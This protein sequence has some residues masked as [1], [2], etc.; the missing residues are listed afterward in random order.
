MKTVLIMPVWGDIAR[1][2]YVS[3]DGVDDDTDP[4]RGTNQFLPWRTSKI[5]L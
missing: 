1:V 4:E 3:L 2:R 5:C